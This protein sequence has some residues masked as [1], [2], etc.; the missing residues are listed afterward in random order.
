RGLDWEVTE[1]SSGANVARGGT[2]DEVADIAFTK[3]RKMGIDKFRQG[4]VASLE[5][6]VQFTAEAAARMQE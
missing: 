6:N 5:R 4:I 1:S 2:R 3:I